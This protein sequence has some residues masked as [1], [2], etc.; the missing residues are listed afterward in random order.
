MSPAEVVFAAEVLKNTAWQCVKCV[1][2]LLNLQHFRAAAPKTLHMF[3]L[4]NIMYAYHIRS[5]Y[6]LQKTSS[7]TESEVQTACIQNDV[8][9]GCVTGLGVHIIA[10]DKSVS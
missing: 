3:S 4:E 1:C 2:F 6:A 7:H 8:F 5:L 10:Y 9:C